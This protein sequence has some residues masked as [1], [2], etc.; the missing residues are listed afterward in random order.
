MRA[1][2]ERRIIDGETLLGR[3]YAAGIIVTILALL[4]VVAVFAVLLLA[5]GGER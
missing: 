1:E 5:A 3:L 4:G 2:L